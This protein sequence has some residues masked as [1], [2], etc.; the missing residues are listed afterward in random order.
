MD[1]S[2]ALI[3]LLISFPVIFVIGVMI[4]L[5][6]K[7]PVFF[8]QERIGYQ[9]K[10]F[11]IW[12]FRTMKQESSE[13]EHQKYIQYLLKEGCQVE[14][15][16]DR[17]EKYVEYLDSR[18]TK[19]GR[20]LRATSLDE[21]PQLFNVIAGNMSLVGPRPHP[22]YEVKEYKEWYKRRLSVKPGLTG[23]SKLNLRCTPK[24]YEEAILYDLWYV[25]HWN[26]SLDF[27]ILVLT[28]PFV[29]FSKDAC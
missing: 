18:T 2:I 26:I 9:K 4:K 14:K 27:R 13:D 10:G 16:T 21:L 29:I 7:G 5:T 8:K 6:S 22:V 15:N 17:I 24:N 11:K 28:I 19:I 20:I 12:K 23:W 1:L 25:D 3:F